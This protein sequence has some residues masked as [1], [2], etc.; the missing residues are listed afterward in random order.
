MSTNSIGGSRGAWGT[1][2]PP[3]GVQIL[4]ISCSFRENL[5]CSRP[6]WRVHAPPSGKSWI[7]H[8]IVLILL[9]ELPAAMGN[10]KDNVESSMEIAVQCN[11]FWY[12]LHLTVFLLPE[13]DLYKQILNAPPPAHFFFIFM[14]FSGKFNRI[15]GCLSPLR[16]ALTLECF[17][18]NICWAS[19]YWP[20]TYIRL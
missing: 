3:L 11:Y 13:A 20:N 19:R 14:Q 15:I 8:W 10:A 2:A 9:H 5:A 16:L 12:R 17:L 4:S 7:R 6:P 18:W 1:H